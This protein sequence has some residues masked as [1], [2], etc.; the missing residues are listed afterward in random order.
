M[1]TIGKPSPDDPAVSVS[2]DLL[3][4]TR[5]LS[6]T[7][8]GIFDDRLRPYGASS[9]QFA[10]LAL[11]GKTEPIT[12][13]AIARLQHLDK[14][15][16]TRNLRAILSEGWAVEV[17][18]NANGRS[19]PIALSPTGKALLLNAQSAWLAA[20]NQAKALLGDDGTI[21]IVNCADR[22]IQQLFTT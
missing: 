6:K 20:Q 15:T 13:A 9:A 17:R 7:I 18:E 2:E 14:S 21:V 8:T 19:R 3:V 16:L 11:I 22:I 12:R 1:K 4:Q 10:L 5:L